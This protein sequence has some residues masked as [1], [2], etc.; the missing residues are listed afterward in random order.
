[1]TF[2]IAGHNR[3]NASGDVKAWDTWQALCNNDS[4]LVGR[5]NTTATTH[6]SRGVSGARGLMDVFAT[7]AGL[8]ANTDLGC[9]IR[10]GGVDRIVYA[11]NAAATLYIADPQGTNIATVTFSG[12]APTNIARIGWDHV[13]SRVLIADGANKAATQIRQYTVSG[14]TLTNINSDITLSVAPANAGP[15]T[16]FYGRNYILVCDTAGSATST[17][18]QRYNRVT[19]T[20]VDT[21]TVRTLGSATVNLGALVWSVKYNKLYMFRYYS[22]LATINSG[23]FELLDID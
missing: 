8:A 22:T 19:G 21:I 11:A 7:V 18:I 17:T 13:N 14:T 12:T 20:K 3:A 4:L 15:G 5:D 16:I 6:N 2:G 1:L 10:V 9:R 23:L